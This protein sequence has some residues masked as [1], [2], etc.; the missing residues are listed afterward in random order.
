MKSHTGTTMSLGK[1]S[2][3]STSIRQKLNTKSPTGAVLVGVDDVMPMV[4]WLRCFYEA[5]GYRVDGSGMFQDN[6]IEIL[7]EKNERASS[8]K[9]IKHINIRY[10]F[11]P[12]RVNAGEVSIKYCPTYDMVRDYFTKPMQGAKFREFRDAILNV[13]D[14]QMI[15][16]QLCTRVHWRKD[17]NS[18]KDQVK[19]KTYGDIP[20]M[21][22][23]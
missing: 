16:Y 6:Q 7:L 2:I 17:E 9:R 10:F 20:R 5:Q 19:G 21:V 3:Y 14:G 12:D 13:Q 23:T 8:S 4:L 22:N 1:G 18:D 11:V 15:D